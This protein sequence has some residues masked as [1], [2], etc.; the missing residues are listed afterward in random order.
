MGIKREHEI[1]STLKDYIELE[2]KRSLF[3][4]TTYEKFYQDCEKSKLDLRE[5][6]S[7]LKKEGKKVAGY[8][9]TSKS[10]TIFNYRDIGPDLI[11]FITDTSETKIG[12]LCPGSHIPIYDHSYLKLF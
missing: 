3:N 5:I 6:L 9:A 4:E 2:E 8:G 12:K 1:T 10:T 7:N 11:Q